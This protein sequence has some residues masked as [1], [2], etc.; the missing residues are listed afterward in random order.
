MN[1]IDISANNCFVCGPDNPSGLRI[2]FIIDDKDV[3]RAE[4]TPEEQHVGFQ[5]TTHGGII[6]SL[7]DDVMANWLFLKGFPAQTAKCDLRYKNSLKTGETVLLEGYHIKTKSRLAFMHGLVK[8]KNE[9]KIIA[10][11]HAKFMIM[12]I[13]SPM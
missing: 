1:E 12:N 2:N 8:T 5:N 3:C 4:F 9:E 13:Q 10:E 11:C 6:F 7:L